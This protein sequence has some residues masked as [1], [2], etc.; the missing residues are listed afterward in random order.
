MSVRAVRAL[1]L[2]T[3]GMAD[4]DRNTRKSLYRGASPGPRGRIRTLPLFGD[5]KA[6]R[7]MI[8]STASAFTVAGSVTTYVT[9]APL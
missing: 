6:A 5:Q 9:G 8:L 7:S 2:P 1:T 4:Q 3:N